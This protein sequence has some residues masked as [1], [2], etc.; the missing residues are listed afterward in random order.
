MSREYR[1]QITDD[2]ELRRIFVELADATH[3]QYKA[4]RACFPE[5]IR[6]TAEAY[7]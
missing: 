4:L 7:P 1:E 6:S 2:S 5:G 3:R